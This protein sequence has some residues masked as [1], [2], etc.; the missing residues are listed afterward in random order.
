MNIWLSVA[1]AFA[2]W[3]FGFL[4]AGLMASAKNTD[5]YF[6]DGKHNG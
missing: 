3:W 1:I 6:K 5:E 2:F 4:I